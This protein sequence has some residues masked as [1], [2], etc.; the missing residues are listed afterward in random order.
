MRARPGPGRFFKLRA[1]QARRAGQGLT[2]QGQAERFYN[3]LE[4]RA[5]FL[6]SF[7]RTLKLTVM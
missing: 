6:Q 1:D 2:W 7:T 3:L 4:V 5:G